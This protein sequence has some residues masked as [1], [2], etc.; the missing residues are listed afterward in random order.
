[1]KTNS[2][3]IAML[4]AVLPSL[5][6]AQNAQPGWTLKQCI[7]YGLKNYGGIRLAQYQ[8][9][10]ANQ[11]AREAISQYLPQVTGSGTFTDNIKL[12]R[13][14]IPANTFGNPEPLT[15]AFGQKYQTNVAA[16]AT[17]T[18][19]DKTLLLGIKANEPNKKL[20][21]LNTR[22]TQEE[23]VYNVAKNYY[24]V[25]VSQQ[26]IALL[27]DNMARTQQVLAILKL[28]RDNGVIQ[29][30]DYTNTEV[31]YNNARSQL[32]LAENSLEL[33]LNQLK[34]QMGVSQDQPLMLSDSNI[35][36][37]LPKVQKQDFDYH[38]LVSFQQ[39]ERNLDLQRI[40]MERTKAGYL[41]T[42]SANASY[43]TLSF[44]N[45][46]KGAF[47]N[48]LGFGTVGL[49]LSLPIFD[50]FRRDAQYQQN[51]LTVLTQEEQQRLNTESFKLQYNNAESQ[52]VR[53]KTNTE[54]DDRTVKLAQEVYDI[55]TLQYK[56][57]TKSLTDLLNADKSYREAQSNY[58][59]SLI[60]YYQAQLDLEQS[61][62]TLLNFY[63][64]L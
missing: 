40:N 52:L 17:Q 62:G 39:G 4:V 29:P 64:Q 61:Q 50:G 9:E 1:M 2:F 19:Y 27:K 13:S 57:G 7:E 54:N 38:N 8:V 14:V 15:I 42:L 30:V 23:I 56:Q 6:K 20:A 32:V 44:S 37:Q 18:I 12:Q 51:K 63:N 31:S 45:E 21:E 58:I 16:Q 35:V 5:S 36:K 55:T 43:G 25:F 10:T 24:Q 60:N 33:A 3:L 11:Q 34:F 41:P 49:R 22:Q 59:N 26:Q 47:Q 53:A 46:F 48:F 28:Q